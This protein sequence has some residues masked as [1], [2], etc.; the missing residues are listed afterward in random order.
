MQRRSPFWERWPT[1]I[2]FCIL[3]PVL[4]FAS[5]E[6]FPSIKFWKALSDGAYMILLWTK[7]E[8]VEFLSM[9]VFSYI[10]PPAWSFCSYWPTMQ[11]QRDSMC[12][13]FNRQ[14]N[15]VWI[16]MNSIEPN[17][18]QLQSVDSGRLNSINKHPARQVYDRG[19]LNDHIRTSNS[20]DGD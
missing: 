6:C 3:F 1:P 2:W 15:W 7:K 16:E 13:N 17:P 18:F 8:R 9:F 14:S 5:H 10:L 12:T 20:E 11:L 19:N 4:N